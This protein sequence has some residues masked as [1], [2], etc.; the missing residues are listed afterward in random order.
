MIEVWLW[1]IDEICMGVKSGENRCMIWA[2][3]VH[4]DFL[5]STKSIST[6]CR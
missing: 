5:N 6:V 4:I 3:I 2:V 1:V